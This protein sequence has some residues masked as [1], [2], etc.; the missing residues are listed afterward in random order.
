MLVNTEALNWHFLWTTWK[1]GIYISLL[2]FFLNHLMYRSFCQIH[3]H[4]PQIS[5]QFLFMFFD[6]EKHLEAVGCLTYRLL[7]LHSKYSNPV[8]FMQ[9]WNRE[10]SIYF[11]KIYL[12]QA[13]KAILF[14]AMWYDLGVLCTS[15]LVVLLQHFSYRK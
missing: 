8:T 14:S 9:V 4:L 7:G 1:Q 5:F 12:C 2:S 11:M 15:L 13:S 3:F 10:I 6:M